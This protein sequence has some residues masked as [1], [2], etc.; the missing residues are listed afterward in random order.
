M[1]FLNITSTDR[2]RVREFSNNA[3]FVGFMLNYFRHGQNFVGVKSP[4]SAQHPNA[5]AL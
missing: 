4:K 2:H 1:A 5:S 3:R